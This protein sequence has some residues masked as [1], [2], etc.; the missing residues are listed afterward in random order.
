MIKKNKSKIKIMIK[1]W[2]IFNLHSKRCIR[3]I[4][5]IKI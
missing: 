3:L 2:K 4:S 1:K 5:K